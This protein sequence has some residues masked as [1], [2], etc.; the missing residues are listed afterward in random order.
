MSGAMAV[1][2]SGGGIAADYNGATALWLGFGATCTASV[3]LLTN[4]SF[5]TSGTGTNVSVGFPKNWYI[6][7]TT[8]IGSS[9]WARATAT[10]GTVST[11][12]LNTW[13][14]LSAGTSW[15]R[16]AGASVVNTCVLLIEIASDA[17]GAGVVYSG[18]V[19]LTADGS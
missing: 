15:S 5:S 17:A 6:P 3:N 9:Y 7:N 13:Q 11:G 16:S 4:G 19:T 2:M 14:S 18:S 8:G 12:T 10:S 1:M